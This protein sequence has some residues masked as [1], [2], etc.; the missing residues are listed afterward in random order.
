[1]NNEN[2]NDSLVSLPIN[3]AK[4]M[5]IA[6]FLQ[7]FASKAQHE[8][9]AL[10]LAFQAKQQGIDLFASGGI[11]GILSQKSMEFSVPINCIADVGE[12]LMATHKSSTDESTQRAI[13]LL[14]EVWA[15]FAKEGIRTMDGEKRNFLD[16]GPESLN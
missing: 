14:V 15:P 10:Q 13:E 11:K 2:L 3:V 7:E 1:M 8:V 16:L 9:F 5:C 4:L 12:M 6:G